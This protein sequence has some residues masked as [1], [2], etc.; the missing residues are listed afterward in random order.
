MNV[1]EMFNKFGI[2]PQYA[3]QT[4]EGL[5]WYVDPLNKYIPHETENPSY[6]AECT[7]LIPSFIADVE[8]PMKEALERYGMAFSPF[9]GAMVEGGVYKS[10][11]K[12]DPDLMPISFVYC[13]QA[14][15]GIFCYQYGIIAF[16]D[17]TGKV[18]VYRFD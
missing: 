17:T 16:I 9:D 5:T 10:K 11:Y 18:T 7:G 4:V 1:Q 2:N 15:M 3:F 8:D 14:D 6:L 12:E 13:P